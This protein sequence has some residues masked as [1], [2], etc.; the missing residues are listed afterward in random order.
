[1]Y[2][3]FLSL[4]KWVT[5]SL[6]GHYDFSINYSNHIICTHIWRGRTYLLGLCV[7]LM[8]PITPIAYSIF[9]VFCPHFT[10]IQHVQTSTYRTYH[11]LE[12]YPHVY[13]LSVCLHFPHGNLHRNRWN[14]LFVCWMIISHGGFRRSA[15]DEIKSIWFW[16]KIPI[17]F[18][19][20]SFNWNRVYT[21]EWFRLSSQ[22]SD[23]QNK[24]CVWAKQN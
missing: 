23:I 14:F 11:C 6:I 20:K 12:K 15:F 13:I 3:H 21:S 18:H 1:M 2:L 8:L 17:G 10:A 19:I 16:P 9:H 7:K 4:A 24:W 5:Q 22:L